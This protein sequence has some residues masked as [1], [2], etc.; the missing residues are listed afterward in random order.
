MTS[1]TA[2]A[3]AFAA[4]H[5]SGCD[6]HRTHAEA[7]H[8]QIEKL[9]KDYS[10]T[11]LDPEATIAEALGHAQGR[12]HPAGDSLDRVELEMALQE[13]MSHTQVVRRALE[14]RVAK[15]VLDT[16]LGSP[17]HSSPWDPQ[18][19]WVRSVRGIVNERVRHS[20]GCT[21]APIDAPSNK[22]MNLTK[23]AG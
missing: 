17:H 16:L 5:F 13:G 23:P 14:A 22:G 15:R 18:T 11:D 19:V 3:R 8:E 20:G 7:V 10:V 12:D 4:T 9:A 21:C 1:H 6:A 2:R